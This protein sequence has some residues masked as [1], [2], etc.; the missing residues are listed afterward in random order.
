MLNKNNT[1]SPDTGCYHK[2]IDSV[3]YRCIYMIMNTCKFSKRKKN[4]INSIGILSVYNRIEVIMLFF[5]EVNGF[6]HFLG[7]KN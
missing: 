7:N 3:P 6:L 1:Q 5:N 2:Y 4:Q